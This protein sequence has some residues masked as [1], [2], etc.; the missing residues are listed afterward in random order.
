MW[1]SYCNERITWIEEALAQWIPEQNGLLN[2]LF[3]SMRYSLF[4]GGK[5]L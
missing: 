2:S 1:K 4:A 3:E 5:G